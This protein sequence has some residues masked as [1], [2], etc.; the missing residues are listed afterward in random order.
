MS[1]Q[2]NSTPSRRLW[3]W[4]WP[5]TIFIVGLAALG[6]VSSAT[7]PGYD[8]DLLFPALILAEFSLFFFF[9]LGVATVRIEENYPAEYVRERQQSRIKTLWWLTLAGIFTAL[10]M[11]YTLTTNH[12]DF[13]NL[14]FLT[15]F[16]LS[17]VGWIAYLNH[18]PAEVRLAPYFE[19]PISGQV[20]W[21]GPLARHCA[22]LD[23]IALQAQVMPLSAFGF[24]DDWPGQKQVVT[25]YPPE[26]GLETIAKLR[27]KLTDDPILSPEAETLQEDLSQLEE[28]LQ[29]AHRSGTRFCFILHGNGTNLMEWEQRKGFF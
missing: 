5:T 12:F 13:Q 11:F 10:L 4:N 18:S 7:L 9:S 23:E 17:F 26:L 24:A 15:N 25:F 2:S 20:H 8:E 21:S 27:E 28:R 16:G 14:L 3:N 19:D 6:A 1:T 29:Q 22:Q